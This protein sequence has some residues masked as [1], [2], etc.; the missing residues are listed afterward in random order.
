MRHV[1]RGNETAIEDYTDHLRFENNWQHNFSH[2]WE[3][4]HASRR[5]RRQGCDAVAGLFATFHSPPRLTSPS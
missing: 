5:K 2:G 1:L 4:T 3:L